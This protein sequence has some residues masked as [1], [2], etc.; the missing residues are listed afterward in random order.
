MLITRIRGG[1]GVFSWSS[2]P[3]E[4]RELFPLWRKQDNDSMILNANVNSLE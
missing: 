2:A 1:C 4:S 3:A